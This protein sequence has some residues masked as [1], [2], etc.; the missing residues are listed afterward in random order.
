MLVG[1]T[2]EAMTAE[3]GRTPTPREIAERTG[4]T[5]EEVVEAVGSVAA[6]RAQSLTAADDADEPDRLAALGDFDPGFEQA[7]DRAALAPALAEP[8]RARPPHP[9]P[10]LR[11]GPVA[12]GDRGARR[13][14]ADARLAPAAARAAAAARG[15][16]DRASSGAS[17]LARR[18]A[19]GLVVAQQPA[20][21]VRHVRMVGAARCRPAAGRRPRRAGGPTRRA[22][23]FGG[24]SVRRARRHGPRAPTRGPTTA[25]DRRGR[26][27]R[28]RPARRARGGGSAFGHA[29]AHVMLLVRHGWSV[30]PE[31]A[32]TETERTRHEAGVFSA[33]AASDGDDPPVLGDPRVP[34]EAQ[35]DGRQADERQSRAAHGA[36]LG[37][38][39]AGARCAGCCGRSGR[40]R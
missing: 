26:D 8:R 40:R 14:L 25:R 27:R 29:R 5:V 37:V 35:R 18:L 20:R 32:A 9:A 38:D 6:R 11:R 3:L 31:R 33:P 13:H 2:T 36:G 22:S 30:L 34:R 24:G 23:A 17:V 1:R 39:V 12:V 28:A 15:A 7:E 16:R 19:G 10:A 21:A 4:R